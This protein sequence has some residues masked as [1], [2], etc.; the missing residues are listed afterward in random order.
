MLKWLSSSTGLGATP[1]RAA[2]GE[3]FQTPSIDSNKD[4]YPESMSPNGANTVPLSL[5]SEVPQDDEDVTGS[6]DALSRGAFLGSGDA[7][8]SLRSW[9]GHVSKQARQ[10]F[11]SLSP[12]SR[13]VLGTG[14]TCLVAMWALRTWER[15]QKWE[16]LVEYPQ[17]IYLY[18]DYDLTF[19]FHNLHGF[20][21]VS[22]HDYDEALLKTEDFLQLAAAQAG[23]KS[24][25]STRVDALILYADAVEALENLVAA[26]RGEDAA[27]QVAVHTCY[28]N[29]YNGLGR[30]MRALIRSSD[31]VQPAYIGAE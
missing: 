28:S 11:S 17:L 30:V 14:T 23:D 24:T 2:A 10:L 15:S 16:P 20:K 29:I 27:I 4:M 8:S 3:K 25:L 9:G 6:E 31:T 18:R 22:E 26:G 12:E 13:Q 21:Y 1:G 7:Q 19:H 5:P